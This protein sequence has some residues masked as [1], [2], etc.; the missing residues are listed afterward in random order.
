[1]ETKDFEY[2]ITDPIN[3]EFI[4]EPYQE[5]VKKHG[6]H[7]QKKHGSWADG[8][9]STDTGLDAMPYEWKPNLGGTVRSSESYESL[10]ETYSNVAHAPIVTR[11]W[12]SE[13]DSIV[14]DGHFKSLNEA[15][16]SS[17]VAS[18]DYLDARAE[19]ENDTWGVPKNAVQPMYGYMDTTYDG[20]K[21]DVKNYGDVKIILKNTVAGRTTVT[22]GDSLDN[23]LIPIRVTDARSGSLSGTALVKA[24]QGGN[25]FEGADSVFYFEAQIHGGISVSDIKS[26]EVNKYG[27]VEQ[28]TYDALKKLGIKVKVERWSK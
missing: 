7:D 6:T 1:L 16:N 13:L 22:A 24:S 28:T 10:K 15:P 19:L 4:P 11:V 3:P 18:A 17:S 26:V 12:G 23:R 20:H 9:G 8:G 27:R 5:D 2:T 14:A 21:P 25:F